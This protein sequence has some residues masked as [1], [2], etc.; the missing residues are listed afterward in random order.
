M[1]EK[2][3]W[4]VLETLEIA[5]KGFFRL[6]SDK[7]ELPD[8][9]VMTHYYVMEFTDWVNVLP[10]TRDGKIVLVEQY[11]HAVGE[12]S[13]EIPGGSLHPGANEDPKAAA[14]RELREETGYTPGEIRL[15]GK[16]FPNPALQ[17]NKIW[18]Y[19]ALD[20]EK[21]HSQELDPFEDIEVVTVEFPEVFDLI[22]KGRIKNSLVIQAIHLAMP[23]LGVNV[24]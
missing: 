20:C 11:R 18:T 22:R 8:K 23:L 10:L 6:R 1:S 12:M 14:L 15:V 16:C 13:L 4:S 19:V 2:K 3:H 24:P 7:F 5:A 17:N 9:R 21:T